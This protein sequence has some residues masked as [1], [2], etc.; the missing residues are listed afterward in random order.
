MAPMKRFLREPL[1]HFVIIGGLVFGIHGAGDTGSPTAD[2]T[3]FEVSQLQVERIVGQFEIAW[4]RP[5][6]ADEVAALIEDFV[7]EEV[8]YREALALGLD[9]DDAIIRRRLRQ[10]M[11]FLSQGAMSALEPDEATLEAHHAAHPERFSASARVTFRQIALED[12]TDVAAVR[13]A[14]ELGADPMSL[15]R[16]VM[17]PPLME[18][19]GALAVDA[20]FGPGFFEGVVRLPPG[21]WQ[22]PVIS[23]YGPHLVELLAVEKDTLMPFESVRP[24]VLQDWQREAAENAR[25]A[26]Y[27]ALRARY[28]V[29]LP[30]EAE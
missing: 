14:I 18:G 29:V 12:Q 25:D 15:G 13:A 22:G 8:Y 24:L 6:S 16:R 2:E 3:V 26:H 10:K 9:R 1:I 11:E 7:R 17:V 30:Q 28:R 21:D 23:A 27:A 4:R 19:V 5:A 20:A